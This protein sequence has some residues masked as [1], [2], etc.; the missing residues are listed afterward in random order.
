MKNIILITSIFIFGCGNDGSNTSSNLIVAV[1]D[2]GSLSTSD[3]TI[4]CPSQSCTKQISSGDNITIDVSP[5]S[6]FFLKSIEGCDSTTETQCNI[7]FRDKALSDKNIV[8]EFQK[9]PLALDEMDIFCSCGP[10]TANISSIPNNV[11]SMNFTD[12][13]LVRVA[14]ADIQP[15]KDVFDWSL[16]DSQIHLAEAY[17]IKISLA[18]V[19]GK[20]TPPWL[21]SAGVPYFQYNDLTNNTTQKIPVPW[22]TSY[23]GYYKELISALGTR[24]DNH[25]SIR[26]VHMTSSTTNGFEMQFMFSAADEARFKALGYTE[27]TLLASW[28]SVIDYYAASF[29]ATALDIEVHPIFKSDLVAQ[30]VTDYGFSKLGNRFGVLA[31]W[32]SVKNA[33]LTYPGMFDLV[34]TYANRSFATVQMV[35]TASMESRQRLSESDFI[36]SI[37]LASEVGVNY[38]EIWNQD[39]L[40]TFLMQT[41]KQSL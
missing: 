19:N 9:T 27:D 15:S 23:L 16:I 11:T 22:D 14:W 10:T 34:K 30:K 18:I 3:N 37:R 1:S 29:K 26:L 38:V 4:N 31:A 28:K 12:G 13:V 36:D 25:P 20:S 7:D 2:G 32:W 24:Y 21:E 35:G 40:N 8:A 41:T 5:N 33:E 17:G 39:L 6:G